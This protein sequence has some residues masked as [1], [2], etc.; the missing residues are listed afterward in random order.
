MSGYVFPFGSILTPVVQTDRSP[1][2]VFVLGVYAS[3]VHAKWF[4]AQGT[5]L[6]RA[7]AVA[8]E[9]EI[10]WHGENAESIIA[11]INVPEDCGHLLPAES[12]FNGPSGQ[13]LDN[14]YLQPLGLTRADA[15]LCDLLPETRL[16]QKQQD[17]VKR[18]Y[19][20]LVDSGRLPKVTVPRRCQPQGGYSKGN[21]GITGGNISHPGGYP[22]PRFCGAF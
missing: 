14:F 18:A 6:V 4:D 2:K 12:R 7:L 3:A 21:I 17:A 10:F 8:S 13:A 15:W 16:N 5:L 1:K 19:Q 20:P 9:P 11:N 22:N